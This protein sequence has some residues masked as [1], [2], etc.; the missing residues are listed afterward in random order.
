MRK[1]KT[2]IMILLCIAV[3]GVLS[4]FMKPTK[5]TNAVAQEGSILVT[6]RS[7]YTLTVAYG[8]L[9]GLEFRETMDYG[10]MLEGTDDKYEKSGRWQNA[11]LG[12]YLLCV[13]PKIKPCILARTEE[14]TMVFNFESAKATE[15]LYTA[16]LEQMAAQPA[17]E[18]FGKI[19]SVSTRGFVDVD[20]VKLS[21]VQFFVSGAISCVLMFLFETPRMDAIMVALPALLYSGIMSCGLAYTFQIVGQKY[22]EATVASLIL[23]LESVFGVLAGAVIL[24]EVLTGREIVGCI[25]MFA[26]IL[27]S[28]VSDLITE[29]FKQRRTA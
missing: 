3:F 12:E 29:K 1:G 8:R 27:L 22:T 14:G 4:F 20:G 10:S 26:A 17:I 11:E 19:L 13:N 15:A 6:G 5:N 28:Q 23:C 21:C 9:T 25:I 2:I 7:G 24:H 16:L 18:G